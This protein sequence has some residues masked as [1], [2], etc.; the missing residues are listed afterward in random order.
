MRPYTLR[1]R[2]V[3]A[4]RV[5]TPWESGATYN[6]EASRIPPMAVT[7]GRNPDNGNLIYDGVE[8]SGTGEVVAYWVCNH[9][10]F[11]TRTTATSS[12]T[13]WR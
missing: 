8:I 3:E 7:T 6:R 5:C 4:D 9:H 10:P 2:L 1:L 13:A 11:E 12:T